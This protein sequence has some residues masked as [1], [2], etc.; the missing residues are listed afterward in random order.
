[1][2]KEHACVARARRGERQALAEDTPL[3]D[4]HGTIH[5]FPLRIGINATD[6]DRLPRGGV[7]RI[8]RM[9]FHPKLA[10]DLDSFR[11]RIDPVP[12][13][14]AHIVIGRRSLGRSATLEPMPR[15]AAVGPLLGEAVVG[16]G[17]YQG[18]EFVLQRGMRDAIGKTG[19][20]AM[21]ARCCAAGLRRARVWRLTLGR[22]HERN[23]DALEPALP[24][25]DSRPFSRRSSSTSPTRGGIMPT[26][27]R[28]TELVRR[29]V[30]ATSAT[31]LGHVWSLGY[32]AIATLV[33]R[34]DFAARYDGSVFLRGSLGKGR[35]VPGLSDID[36]VVLTR[37]GAAVPASTTIQRF[38]SLVQ[39]EIARPTDLDAIEDATN[40]TFGLATGAAAY[41]G[42]RVPADPVSLL[43]RPGV[44][45]D[46]NG[47]RHLAGPR[48]SV[49]LPERDRQQ[50]REAAWCRTGQL[51]AVRDARDHP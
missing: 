7:R 48:R 20:A 22:D 41:H 45:A 18:M 8:E 1:M 51:V 44:P 50:V 12:R 26:S 40:T 31:P 13:P 5:P 47:W 27:R 14:L 38:G 29:F 33:S 9:E 43:N 30:L 42:R 16:V 6:A 37:V 34:A 28:A 36:L 24:M 39:A 23:W 21:R 3:I 32:S 17:V 49:S 19:T 11:H 46:R 35:I 10:L 4:H 15:R 25:T 2:G